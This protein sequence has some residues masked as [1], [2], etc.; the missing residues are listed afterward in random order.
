MSWNYR[1][2]RY[3]DGSLGIHE[4][5]Y[6]DQGDPWTC[7]RDA[8]GIVGEDMEEIR[9]EIARFLIATNKPI[10]DWDDIRG[11]DD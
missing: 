7:T 2:I 11:D 1:L 6:R 9:L 10:L 5:F 4:V 3:E 8:I